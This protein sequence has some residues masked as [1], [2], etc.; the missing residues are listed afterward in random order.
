MAKPRF[1][2]SADNH[3]CFAASGFVPK[4]RAWPFT[5]PFRY[6]GRNA[7]QQA[8][9]RS[10]DVV[11]DA[12][13]GLRPPTSSQAGRARAGARRGWL[14]VRSACPDPSVRPRSSHRVGAERTGCHR[15]RP[16]RRSVRASRRSLEWHVGILGRCAL[17]V[18]GRW[19]IGS[20]VAR[21]STAG[22]L[23][24]LAGPGDDARRSDPNATQP[25]DRFHRRTPA[26]KLV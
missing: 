15:R 10:A 17:L 14:M 11:R 22:R 23:P 18:P 1:Y 21:D 3:S 16:R 7:D 24:W 6:G 9:N 26:A 12:A 5:N 2:L 8:P 13:D 20:D 4:V 25:T 19:G